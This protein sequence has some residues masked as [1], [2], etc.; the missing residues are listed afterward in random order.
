[1]MKG[2]Y[3]RLLTGSS[4]DSLYKIYALNNIWTKHLEVIGC[5]KPHTR[6]D[7]LSVQS[8]IRLNNK[9]TVQ[10]FSNQTNS[11]W[12]FKCKLFM[13]WDAFMISCWCHG[14]SLSLS[15]VS[16]LVDCVLLGDDVRNSLLS[17]LAQG[18]WSRQHNHV[19]SSLN[20]HFPVLQRMNT[21]RFWPHYL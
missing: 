6:P 7:S 17:F 5:V 10:R 2:I 20:G 13:S 9:W 18:N 8:K 16:T 3:Y 14:A 21:S 11:T 15:T 19:R 1:M 4:M 12:F